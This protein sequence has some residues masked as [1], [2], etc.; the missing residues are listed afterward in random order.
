MIGYLTIRGAS[1]RATTV[2]ADEIRA[3]K[4]LE[5]KLDEP[6]RTLVIYGDD[7]RDTC[8]SLEGHGEVCERIERAIRELREYGLLRREAA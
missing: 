5:P 8:L 3:V 4:E 2:R 6:Q 1:G 7:M